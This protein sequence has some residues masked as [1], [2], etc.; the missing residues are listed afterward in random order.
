[1][2]TRKTVKVKK[3]RKKVSRQSEQ[4]TTPVVSAP[5]APS[6]S[7][8]SSATTPP[9]PVLTPKDILNAKLPER[10][11]RFWNEGEF[12]VP[13]TLVESLLDAEASG[14]SANIIKYVTLIVNGM[15]PDIFKIS[16]SSLKDSVRC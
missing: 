15:S 8:T 1:M 4:S 11:V 7:S 3:P 16:L 9:E 2:K 14:S 5:T 6:T 10:E 13:D 12:L